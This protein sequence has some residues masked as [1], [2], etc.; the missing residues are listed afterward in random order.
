[1]RRRPDL[2]APLA[3]TTAIVTGAS[4]GIGAAV[5]LALARRGLDVVA[6]GRSPERL[7]ATAAAVEGV[8]RTC[9]VV[10][11]D[12]ARPDD[13]GRIGARLD[14][15]ATT[16]VV[17]SAGV[18]THGPLHELDPARAEEILAVDVVALAELTRQALA[19]FVARGR[20]LVVNISSTAGVAPMANLALYGASK[21]FVTSLTRAADREVR[22]RG[23][24]AALAIPGPV[25]TPM[26]ADAL[27]VAL[28]PTSRLGRAVE[29][30]YV[31]SPDDTAAGIV[32]GLAQGR[33]VI[34]TDPV[35]RTLA[36]LPAP[37]L[38][39]ID[40]LS[41]ALLTGR[42]HRARRRRRAR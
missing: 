30:S 33:T 34:C 27:G 25:R 38:E 19:A 18:A 8:G 20:G 40:E 41:I 5:A 28:A 37:V 12:L 23:V 1:M 35:D 13:L 15:A 14:D 6:T 24:R 36:R 11:A 4:S 39:R 17:N 9:E 26:L 7:A 32:C 16:V 21:S 42:R 22:R 29:R 2:L 31:R 3:D 10:T